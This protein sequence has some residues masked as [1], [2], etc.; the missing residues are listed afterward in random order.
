MKDALVTANARH[1]AI[2]QRA[3]LWDPLINALMEPTNGVVAKLQGKVRFGFTSYKSVTRPSL[4][5][6]CPVL[7]NSGR[8]TAER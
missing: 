2:D 3:K 5:P 7:I 1:C 8:R 6:A 4:A